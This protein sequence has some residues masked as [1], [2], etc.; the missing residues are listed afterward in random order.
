MKRNFCKC[1]LVLSMACVFPMS[2]NA[3][4]VVTVAQNG[5]DVVATLAGSLNLTGLTALPSPFGLTRAI[6]PSRYI[7]LGTSP[8]TTGYTGLIGAGIFGPGNS[9]TFSNADSGDGFGLDTILGQNVLF[10]PVPYVSG[11]QLGGSSTFNNTTLASLGL[12]AGQYTFRSSS[13]T[14]TISIG[15]APAPAPVPE[16]ATW[17][18][19]IGGFGLVGGTLRRRKIAGSFA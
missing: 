19:F 18:M 11:A 17:M 13:D 1:F 5:P 7:G 8:L 12:T 9:F 15:S 2:A 3:A 4:I 16:P 14:V 10:L 6:Q